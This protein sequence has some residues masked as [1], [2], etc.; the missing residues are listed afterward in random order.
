MNF[1]FSNEGGIGGQSRFLKNVNGMW[2]LQECQK[3]WAKAGSPWE[4]SA[5]V[6]AC[7]ELQAPEELLEVDNPDLLL[8]GSM[9]ERINS[10]LVSHGM[11]PLSPDPAEAPRFANL[12][13]HSLA[14]RYRTVLEQIKTVTGKPLNRIYIVGGGSRNEFL[15]DLIG[16]STKLEVHRGAVESSTIGNLAVQLAVL[17]GDTS[18][19]SGAAAEAV[20]RWSRKLCTSVSE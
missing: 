12:I 18:S 8:Q 11:K 2:L 4:T 16:A 13:F 15:N 3:H 7:E 10:V 19:K 20:A 17:D 9:P 1:N 14:A 6:K 5:L